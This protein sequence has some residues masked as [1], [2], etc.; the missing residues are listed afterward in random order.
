V[1]RFTSVLAAAS[2]AALGATSLLAG[3]ASGASSTVPTMNIALNGA[4]GISVSGSTGSGAVKIVTTFSGKVPAGGNGPAFA[5]FRAN[6]GAS[7]QQAIAA[8]QRAHG[9]INA[10]NPYGALLVSGGPG[11]TQAVLTPGSWVALNVTG[12]GKPGAQPFTVTQSASPAALPAANETETAIEFG[13]R[14]PR[15]LHDG[16]TL[17]AIN[18]GWLVH[19]DIFIGVRSAAGGR[20]AMAL[21][22]AGKDNGAGRF[23]THSFFSASGPVSHGAVQQEVLN[24]K[25]GY[26]V[27]ACFMD[28]QDGREHTRVGMERLVKVVR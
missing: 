20:T 9:D 23:F 22:R 2:V 27:E 15:V 4:T 14:G 19:M 11:T 1:K 8:V 16:T 21:L 12:N 7:F 10:L 18:G 25:P 3:G 24:V 13:F 17:R 5:L 28:T 6:P 26:Y